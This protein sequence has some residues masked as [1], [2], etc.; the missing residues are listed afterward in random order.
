SD[1]SIV[2]SG[3]NTPRDARKVQFTTSLA[4]ITDAA[5]LNHIWQGNWLVAQ[6]QESVDIW[7]HAKQISS[8][9]A[10]NLK[11][12]LDDT[13]DIRQGDINAT[14]LNP[15]RLGA[16]KGNFS[17]GDVA[18]YKGQDVKGYKPLSFSPSDWAKPLTVNDTDA[19]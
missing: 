12:L 13:F 15:L 8:N 4:S 5:P 10:T 6:N 9:L 7:N 3:G 16:R 17:S 14:F 19:I 2:V 11:M 1:G 18:I